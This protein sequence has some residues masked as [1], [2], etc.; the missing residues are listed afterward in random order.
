M[1]AAVTN[2]Y[3]P[4][5]RQIKNDNFN[6]FFKNLNDIPL[7]IIEAAFG[8]DQFILPEQ[9]NII[10]VRCRDIIWQQYRLIN[11]VIKNLPDKFDKVIWIDADILFDNKN[12]HYEMSDKLDQYK[13]V[14]S[15][16]IVKLNSQEENKYDIKRSVTKNAL[17]N[18]KNPLNDKFC[19]CL[20]M[21]SIYATGFSWGVRRELVEKYGIYDYWITG[22]SDNALVLGIWGDWENNFISERLNHKMKNHFIEW[23]IPFNQYVNGQVSCIEETITHLWHGNRNYK[24][25][26]ECL[27]HFDPYKDICISKEG[28]FEWSTEK[29][30]MKKCCKNMC[31]NYDINFKPFL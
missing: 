24:K 17:E 3:N 19:S 27:K 10:R 8:D 14:Q 7:Y 26:W 21:S 16:S 30:E 1:I 6:K 2:F 5:K 31:Y 29:L 28:V 25:R 13:I 18:A 23:A 20:D 22:S 11:L 15:Y 9:N 12:W 4:S